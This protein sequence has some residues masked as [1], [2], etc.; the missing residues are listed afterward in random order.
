[1]IGKKGMRGGDVVLWSSLYLAMLW[2]GFMKL[3]RS[4]E[5]GGKVGGGGEGCVE[6]SG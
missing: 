6:V 4:W 3:R 1:M 2:N 5:G